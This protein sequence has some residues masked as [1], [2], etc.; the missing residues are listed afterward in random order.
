M[1]G[2]FQGLTVVDLF[3]GSGALGIECLSRGAASC[4]FVE[5]NAKAV[6]T[7]QANLSSLGAGD[8]ATV[9]RADAPGWLT[10][11]TSDVFDL[12]LADPPYAKGYAAELV[13]RFLACP[14][15]S[16]FWLEHRSD[17]PIPPAPALR[18]RRYGDTTLSTMFAPT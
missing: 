2:T 11:R 7:I 15:A 13:E 9:V 18:Q 8:V 10:R 4:V 14:F 3:A 17:E 6:T 1:G 5:S 12:A 16:E